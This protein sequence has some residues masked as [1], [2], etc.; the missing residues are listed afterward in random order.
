MIRNFAIALLFLVG[1]NLEGQSKNATITGTLKCEE[2]KTPLKEAV[3]TIFNGQANTEIKANQNGQ[4][5]LVLQCGF[6]Y[7][8]CF[9]A[10]GYM[11]KIFL[12]NLGNITKKEAKEGF[13]LTI[14]MTLDKDV[15]GFSKE[16]LD[17]PIA[18]FD[19]DRDMDDVILDMSFTKEWRALYDAEID[20][21]KKIKQ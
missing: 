15:S 9:K 19:Y 16:I 21:L 17:M 11:Q 20:R 18:K 12:F 5:K 14:D 1:L 6:D 10:P 2:L 7:K 13:E 8:V 4:Y 3:I